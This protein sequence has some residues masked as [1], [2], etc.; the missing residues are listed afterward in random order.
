MFR[1][2]SEWLLNENNRPP[3]LLFYEI[4]IDEYGSVGIKV[5]AR[6]LHTLFYEKP[7]QIIHESSRK[8]F[9][10]LNI[11]RRNQNCVKRLGKNNR[12]NSGN[13]VARILR[14]GKKNV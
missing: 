6:Y 5:I 11:L 8:F 13:F 10:N 4:T 2:M 14:L 7:G 12:F 9:V 3:M 1:E